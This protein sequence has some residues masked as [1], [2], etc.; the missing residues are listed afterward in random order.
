M[1]EFF[2]RKRRDGTRGK[3]WWT[4]I[5]GR[6]VST[7]CQDLTAAKL[8]KRTRERS[9]ADPRNAA[10]HRARLDNA[11]RDTE[12][13]LVRRDRSAA[14]LD[15]CSQKLGHFARLW[16]LDCPLASID[17]RRVNAYIDTRL[18]E[19]ASR[20]TVRDELAFLRQLLKIA[21]RSGSFAA[22]VDD[23]LPI[24]FDPKIKPVTRWIRPEHLPKL[25]EHVTPAH[26]GL[27]AFAVAT[28]ARLGECYR[29]RRSDVNLKAGTVTLRGTKTAAAK[30]TIPIAPFMRPL[31]TRALK[32]GGPDLLFRVWPKIQ[33]DMRDA[34][35]RAGVPEVTP[36]DL[37][38]SFG[39]WHRARGFEP[40]LIAVLLGHTT[41]RLAQT[42]YA[43]VEGAELKSLVYKIGTHANQQ[44]ERK[45]KTSAK[46]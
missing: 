24:H 4:H 32:A 12:A 3:T 2:R 40:S 10:A 45:G 33:R 16:G 6:R 7:K 19:K 18:A 44:I 9:D 43:T 20:T 39:K 38:R 11:I 41:D 14:T 30:R 21:R 13:E 17:A 5:G 28:G 29:A 15:R 22:H 34:C 42:T 31:L 46:R 36:N 23:V 8:W 25:L 26:A 27:I 37:R 1:P 35:K